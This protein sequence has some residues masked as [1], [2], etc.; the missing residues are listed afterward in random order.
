MANAPGYL[1]DYLNGLLG[2]ERYEVRAALAGIGLPRPL[3]LALL[4]PSYSEHATTAGTNANGIIIASDARH[5]IN[6]AIAMSGVSV[7]FANWYDAAGLYSRSF[8]GLNF[9]KSQAIADEII[10]RIPDVLAARPDVV[11]LECLLSNSIASAGAAGGFTVDQCIAAMKSALSQLAQARVKVIVTTELMRMQAAGGNYV[12]SGKARHVV[13][14]FNTW[15]RWYAPLVGV[16]VWDIATAWE[17]PLDVQSEPAARTYPTSAT[18][19]AIGALGTAYDYIHRSP[20]AAFDQ[21]KSLSRIL[22]QLAPVNTVIQASVGDQ[23]DA[24]YNPYGNRLTNGLFIGSGGVSDNG[25]T[26]ASSPPGGATA[27][28]AAGWRCRRVVGKGSASAVA[29]GSTTAQS[30]VEPWVDRDGQSRGNRQCLLFSPGGNAVEVFG[31]HVPDTN[32]TF[33]VGEWIVGQVEVDVSAYAGYREITLFSRD[34]TATVGA[35]AVS[36]MPFTYN[37]GNLPFPAEA[38]SGVLQTPP[39]QIVN[40]APTIRFQ[41]EVGVDGGV[42]G[43]PLVKAG[44]AE[45]RRV[46]DPRTVAV[47]A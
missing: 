6:W 21:A 4:G 36:M 47:A 19:T 12:A 23:Y 45:Y 31:M 25:V 9:G 29:S 37:F 11:I 40:D 10:A 1:A 30:Y 26:A 24:T 27:G 17:N 46:E 18:A 15:L 8:S 14:A 13:R 3:R 35:T 28:V 22:Q 7:R 42:A 41:L 32:S 39:M 16:V 34:M 20:R 44:A 43:S 5:P 33:A 38:W 2:A